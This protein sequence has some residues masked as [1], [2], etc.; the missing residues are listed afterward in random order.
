LKNRSLIISLGFL[1]VTAV[2]AVVFLILFLVSQG[3]I[4]ALKKKATGLQ[5]DLSQSRNAQA[6]EGQRAPGVPEQVGFISVLDGNKDN[7]AVLPPNSLQGQKDLTLVVYLHGMGSTFMEPFLTP[8]DKPV[9]QALTEHNPALVIASLNYRGQSAWANDVAV[10]DINQNIR[11][12]VNR[13]PISKIVIM[14]TSM[15]GCSALAYSYLAADDIKAKMTGVVAAEPAGDLALLYD[16]T[17]SQ[18]VKSGLI[19]AFGGSPQLQPQGYTSRSILNNTDKIAP[20]LRFAIISAKQ[21]SVIPPDFQQAIMNSLKD[22]KLSCQLIEVDEKHGVPPAS[23]FVS[24]LDY[25]ILGN[26]LN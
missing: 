3:Q 2:T 17:K 7:M 26:S 16:K 8:K 12:I 5:T 11:E 9:S 14:G 10:A 20:G 6:F 23:A 25:V 4:G 1:A 24:G 22:K 15:G 13:F 19:G 21:D 18:I